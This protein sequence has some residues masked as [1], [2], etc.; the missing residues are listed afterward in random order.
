MSESRLGLINYLDA[1]ADRVT[2]HPKA[3]A[4]RKLRVAQAGKGGQDEP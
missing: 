1:I 2:M 3:T 4:A